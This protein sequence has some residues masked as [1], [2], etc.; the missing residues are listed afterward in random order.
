MKPRAQTGGWARVAGRGD[1]AVGMEGALK[2][3]YVGRVSLVCVPG[4][5][6][7]D[8][9]L[10]GRLLLLVLNLLCHLP[11]PRQRLSRIISQRRH[12]W[13]ASPTL[14]IALNLTGVLS[15]FASGRAH[16]VRF[17][18]GIAMHPLR[19]C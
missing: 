6:R 4:R 7:G 19:G 16:G 1:A 5:E 8:Q 2:S 18:R 12:G 17:T 13:D 14:S 10:V 3:S 9:D 15:G 11:L